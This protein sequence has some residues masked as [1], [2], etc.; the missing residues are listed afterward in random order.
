MR[1]CWDFVPQIVQ[2]EISMVFLGGAFS[3]AVQKV[4]ARGDFRVQTSLGGRATATTAKPEWIRIA[5][6]V[7]RQLPP[8]LYARVDVVPAGDKLLWMELE[9]LDPVLFFRMFP[10]AAEH[11]ADT[12]KHSLLR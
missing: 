11:L 5:R 1:S 4:P 10:A 8:L 6:D 2:G 12:I 3:H 7:L 9:A